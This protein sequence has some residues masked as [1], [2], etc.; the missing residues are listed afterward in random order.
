MNF[1][2]ILSTNEIKQGIIKLSRKMSTP[3]EQNQRSASFVVNITTTRGKIVND[4]EKLCLNIKGHDYFYNS[5]TGES[6]SKKKPWG[7]AKIK[8][9]NLL[10]FVSQNYDDP[11]KVDKYSAKMLSKEA[12]RELQKAFE[13]KYLIICAPGSKEKIAAAH[14]ELRLKEK[15]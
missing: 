8:I 5:T 3:V 1:L 15:N 7:I 6:I 9:N 13:E 4:G 2:R 14:K 10:K 12:V 11:I